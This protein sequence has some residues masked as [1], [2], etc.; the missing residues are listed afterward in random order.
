MCILLEILYQD[1]FIKLH[2][3]YDHLLVEANVH[4][5]MWLLL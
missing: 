5:Y 2:E 1:G 4:K 3:Q